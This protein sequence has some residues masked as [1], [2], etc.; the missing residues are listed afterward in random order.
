MIGRSQKLRRD[1]DGAA[2]FLLF[3]ARDAN[4]GRHRAMG[5]PNTRN[6][7]SAPPSATL[8]ERIKSIRAERNMTL[9]DLEIGSNVSR[10]MISKVERG[11][12]S[13]TFRVLVAI[14][15][16]L[17][18]STSRLIGAQAFSGETELT[19]KADRVSF[20]DPE[21]GF[22]RHL[23][24]PDRTDH[25]FEFVMHIIPAGQTTGELPVYAHPTDKY[26]LIE[27][28]EVELTMGSETFV[29]RGGDSLYFFLNQPYTFTNRSKKPC[30][31]YL[32]S[33]VR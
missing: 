32:A 31:Y 29:L 24:S 19:R 21:T 28:G 26:V 9:R 30:R 33:I 13:P 7:R 4:K 25:K 6:K 10:A 22:E 16:G 2:P 27:E 15:N 18:V 3:S 5:S 17:G 11:E 8:G 1:G 14:A 23:L 20:K 12:K